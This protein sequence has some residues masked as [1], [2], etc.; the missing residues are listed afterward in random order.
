MTA[1]FSADDGQTSIRLAKDYQPDDGQLAGEWRFIKFV[2]DEKVFDEDWE[3]L[4]R[5]VPAA[6]LRMRRILCS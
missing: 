1:K 3:Q 5:W 4:L 6:A 2:R